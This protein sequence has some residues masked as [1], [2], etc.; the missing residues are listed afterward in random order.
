M[1][2]SGGEA[3]EKNHHR[4]LATYAMQS[5]QKRQ[6]CEFLVIHNFYKYD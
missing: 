2:H 3:E 1:S 4:F 6:S 5:E